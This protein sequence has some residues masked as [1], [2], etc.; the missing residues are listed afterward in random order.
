M[1]RVLA[2]SLWFAIGLVAWLV[3]ISADYRYCDPETG[4]NIVSASYAPDGHSILVSKM[5]GESDLW[6]LQSDN[7]IH[8]YQWVT[9]TGIIASITYSPDGR[10]V[11]TRSEEGAAKLWD[12]ATGKLL[13][14]FRGHY[15]SVT[16][17][18]YARMDKQYSSGHTITPNYVTQKRAIY[19]SHCQSKMYQLLPLRRTVKRSSPVATTVRPDYGIGPVADCYKR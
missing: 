12:T 15:R 19:C 7:S 4:Q 18:V 8:N 17:A 5:F 13:H 6:S 11:L 1:R 9:H 10:T 2:F 14:I 16:S 3:I